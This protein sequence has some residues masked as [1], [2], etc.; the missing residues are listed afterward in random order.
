M[1]RRECSGVIKS[2]R[3][4]YHAASGFDDR[5]VAPGEA[6]HSQQ[7]KEPTE[8]SGHQ[9]PSRVS[10]TF[11]L[12]FVARFRGKSGTNVR[13]ESS[14]RRVEQLDFSFWVRSQAVGPERFRLFKVGI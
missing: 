7:E 9:T 14:S 11:Y 10:D 4:P 12:Q 3:T 2:K 6:K 5:R 1:L 8:L 13:D